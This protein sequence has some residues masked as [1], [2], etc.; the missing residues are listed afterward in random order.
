MIYRKLI[1]VIGGLNIFT[2]LVFKIRNKYKGTLLIY[3]NAI[4]DI[5]QTGKLIINTGTFHFGK[6]WTRRN[7][8]HSILFIGRNAT[9]TVNK[10]FSIYSNARVYVHHD[11]VL[12]LGSGYINNNFN[13]NC[14]ERIEIGND[15]AIAECVTIR[16]SD[17][18]DILNSKHSKTKPIKIGNNVWIGMHVI[19]LKGVTIGDGAV[20]AAGS[21]INKNVPAKCL[22]GGVPA[23]ILKENIEWKK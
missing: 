13:L 22:V 1:N 7:P 21:L 10:G 2:T 19:I 12:S 15:V 3:K 4:L 20:I 6:S 23:K 8:F 14:F 9:V 18:H 16:D 17:N 5:H 11:S